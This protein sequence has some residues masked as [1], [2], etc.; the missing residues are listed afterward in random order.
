MVTPEER[1]SDLLLA[2]YSDGDSLLLHA[3]GHTVPPGQGHKKEYGEYMLII[4]H[5]ETL[6]ACKTYNILAKKKK[7]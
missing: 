7:H 2:V 6:A 1:F 3:D 4:K 5:D